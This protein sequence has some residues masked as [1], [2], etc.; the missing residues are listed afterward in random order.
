MLHLVEEKVFRTAYLLIKVNNHY[1]G[2]LDKKKV[3]WDTLYGSF[4]SKEAYT[5]HLEPFAPIC[6][7]LWKKK[8]SGE[9]IY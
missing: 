9:P 2:L 1:M 4:S 7:T 5:I 6:S 3:F 8:F